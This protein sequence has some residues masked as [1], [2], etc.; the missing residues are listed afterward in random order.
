MSRLNLVRKFIVSGAGTQAGVLWSCIEIS[1][2][3]FGELC[4][5]IVYFYVSS[6][7]CLSLEGFLEYGVVQSSLQSQI[8]SHVLMFTFQR[9]FSCKMAT[10]ANLTAPLTKVQIFCHILDRRR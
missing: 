1:W 8:T 3:N 2:N 4:W 9:D 10:S 7:R 5:I 6:S